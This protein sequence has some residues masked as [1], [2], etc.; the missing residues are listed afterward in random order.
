MIPHTPRQDAPGSNSQRTPPPPPK[1]PARK[2]SSSLLLFDR[3]DV[4]SEAWERHRPDKYDTFIGKKDKCASDFCMSV[5]LEFEE[6]DIYVCSRCH[7]GFCK[8]C[9]G[10]T[11]F[12]SP[13]EVR[14]V[15][16]LCS[17][18]KRGPPAWRDSGYLG[19]APQ[20]LIKSCYS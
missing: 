15:G 12:K 17:Q 5:A 16:S 8:E 1:R 19:P 11:S 13:F 18:L 14:P 6:V 10:Q 3:P 4:S 9:I 20:V 7:H 2:C